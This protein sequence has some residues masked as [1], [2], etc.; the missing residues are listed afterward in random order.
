MKYYGQCRENGV[1]LDQ[2]IHEIFFPNKKNG[3]FVECGAYNGIID[4]TCLFFEETMDW[5]GLNIE[6]VP[7]LFDKLIVNRPNSINEHYALSSKNGIATFTNPLH[8][9]LGRNFGCGSLSHSEEHMK[10]I[11]GC[12]MDVFEVPTIRFSE[13]FKKHNLPDID[14]F[15]LDVE[16][17]E[18]EALKGILEI[19]EHA[20]PKVFCIEHIMA[21]KDPIVDMIS[22]FY[23]YHSTTFHDIFFTKK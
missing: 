4:S 22:P 19:P 5:K 21:E 13:L 12:K 3:F 7:Y 18:E 9:T 1:R 23:N 14:L 16:G 20:Y 10:G 2:E 11:R 8:P 17:H 15:I 6:A